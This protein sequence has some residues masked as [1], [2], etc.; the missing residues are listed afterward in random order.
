MDRNV[1]QPHWSAD[2]RLLTVLVEND[3]A[4]NLRRVTVSDGGMSEDLLPAQHDATVFATTPGGRMVALV[5]TPEQPYEVCAVEGEYP[6]TLSKQND[7]FLAQ[8]KLA[9]TEET[10]FKS[11]DGTEVHGFLVHALDAPHR[12]QGSRAAASTR[13]PA[14]GV[15]LRVQ[16][17]GAA[18]CRPRLRGDPAQ[19]TRRYRPG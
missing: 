2:G 10:R 12:P 4:R 7:S 19:P 3:G 6:R 5:S 18:I 13:R 17:R 16:L 11:A 9:P 1:I 15:H 14:I 8:V